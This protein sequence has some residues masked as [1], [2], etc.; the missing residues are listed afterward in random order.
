MA[1]MIKIL[2]CL[3]CDYHVLFKTGKSYCM[4]EKTEGNVIEYLDGI[5]S[6][7]PLPDYPEEGKDG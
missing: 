2:N 6:W 1:K 7:C 3:T 5:P 4:H